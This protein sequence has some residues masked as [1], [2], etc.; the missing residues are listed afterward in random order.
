MASRWH[1][2]SMD[3]RLGLLELRAEHIKPFLRNLRVGK[4]RRA[5]YHRVLLRY[6]TRLHA[7]QLISFNPDHLRA[8]PKHLPSIALEFLS[9]LRPTR[10]AGT[11]SAYSRAIRSLHG[12]I[13]CNGV[14]LQRMRRQDSTRWLEHL[15]ERGLH[16]QTRLHMIMQA[17]AYLRW[18][19]ERGL[20]RADPDD[21][22]RSA[23]RPKLPTYL[24]RPYSPEADRELQRR[25]A[26]SKDPLHHGLLLMRWTGMRAGELVSLEY[27]CTR[28]DPDGN[29]YLKV[30]LGKLKT[31]RL[32]PLN[33]ET[34][35]LIKRMQA[36][37]RSRRRWLLET[38]SKD[39]VHYYLLRDAL[40]RVGRG[41]EDQPV[42]TH[43]LR[44]TYATSLLSGG[45]SLVGI[46]NLLGHRDFRMTLRYAA[47]TQDTLGREYFKALAQVETRYG[48]SANT[49]PPSPAT[50]RPSKMLDDILRWLR[51]PAVEH[52]SSKLLKRIKRLRDELQEI[53]TGP[54]A[55]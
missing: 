23:D 29:R 17:R 45:M 42:V 6:L 19:A 3:R 30:P 35:E 38:Q 20:L 1:R 13:D 48:L 28:S 47:I 26:A 24:P 5:I 14:I 21:L 2:W 46:M 52:G 40:K 4:R 15:L 11:C 51:G 34:F 50:V 53:E 49:K 18:L 36:R 37:G 33:S 32:V 16:A 7:E 8:L 43:R 55:T 39:R 31:E 12:W 44:H 22:I 25:F 10:T 27:A 41:L 9:S 54:A